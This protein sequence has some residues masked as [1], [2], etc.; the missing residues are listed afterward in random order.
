[1]NPILS[2]PGQFIVREPVQTA[3]VDR[4]FARGGCIETADQVQQ[5]GFSRSG[6]SDDGHHFAPADAQI[7]VFERGYPAHAL[8][9]LAN[10][11][12]LDQ[13]LA[14]MSYRNGLAHESGR[15]R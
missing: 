15:G 7:H 13:L 3:A 1:M 5:R 10:L 6:W 12:E 8:K 14:M 4:N 9:H 11:R 2:Q